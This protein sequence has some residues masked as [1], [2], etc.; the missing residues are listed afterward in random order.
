[1][2]GAPHKPPHPIEDPPPPF[3][4]SWR[5]VYVMVLCY[6]AALIFVFYI[7]TRVFDS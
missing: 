6:L 7:F 2:S 1:V 3:L 5:R 4:S